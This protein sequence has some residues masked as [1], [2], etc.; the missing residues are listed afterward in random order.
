MSSAGPDT[1][2][3]ILPLVASASLFVRPPEGAAREADDALPVVDLSNLPG[4]WIAARRG[5]RS[6]AQVLRVLCAA[7]PARGW[8]TGVEEMVL[9]RATQL[10]RGALGGEVTRFT[11]GEC[12]AVGSR[13]EQSFAGGVRHGEVA[14]A[15]HGRHWLGFAGD[16]P[17]DAVLCTLVCTERDAATTGAQGCEDSAR[18][19]DPGGHVGRGAAAQPRG[20]GP[21]ALGG[22]A[23]GGCGSAPGGVA[24]RCGA[25][26]RPT[27]AAT[28]LE[29][30]PLHGDVALR[31]G[32]GGSRPHG[33]RGS[34]DRRGGWSR[35]LCRRHRRA[36][37]SWRARRRFDRR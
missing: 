2:P 4:A 13:F 21:A 32:A 33:A 9:A 26:D 20:A 25:A 37:R 29:A 36:R 14:L 1:I 18:G 8:A 11:T 30:G 19:S 15:V 27:A 35:S 3:E 12:T 7:A 17:R 34:H 10:A 5:Y 6:D 31:S 23:S 22:A 28:R 24:G 16:D